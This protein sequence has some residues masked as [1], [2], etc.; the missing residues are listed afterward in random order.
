M[1]TGLKVKREAGMAKAVGRP[2]WAWEEMGSEVMCVKT[3]QINYSD[4][5]P[6]SEPEGYLV[7]FT[8]ESQLGIL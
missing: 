3:L 8:E 7:W 1:P 2:R 4:G 5:L 6:C